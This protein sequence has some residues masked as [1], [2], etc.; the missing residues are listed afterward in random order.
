MAKIL[1]SNFS[2][3][4]K[5]ILASLSKERTALEFRDLKVGFK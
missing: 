5:P 2:N 3:C 1:D 4:Q